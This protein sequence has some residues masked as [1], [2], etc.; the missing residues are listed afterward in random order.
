M[1]RLALLLGLIALPALALA[2][3]E[4][5]RLDAANSVVGFSYS[6]EGAGQKGRMPVKSAEILLDLD[7]VPASRVAVTLDPTRAQAGFVFATEAMK[8]ANVLDTARFPEIRFRSI[9]VAG[10]L[11]DA[12]VTGNLTIRD[13]TRPVTLSA[14]LYRQRG[15]DAGERNRLVILLTGSVSRSAFGA[16]G[17]PGFVG[18]R[19]ELEILA[20]IEK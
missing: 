3:P 16:D 15:T 6:F 17:F 20:R 12:T 11:S 1:R 5:Y 2:A 13:V 10:G 18:D 7:N 4:R 9:S 8:G 14:R 19:I